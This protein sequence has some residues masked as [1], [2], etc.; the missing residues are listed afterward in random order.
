[1]LAVTVLGALGLGYLMLFSS[2]LGARSVEVTGI[3]LLTA[4]EVRAAADVPAG[5]PLSRLDT[6]AVAGRVSGLLPVAAVEVVRSWPSTVT[7]RV[8]ERVPVA[9]IVVP[10]GARL[11]DRTGV[12]FATI[13]A[14]P[15][16]TPELLSGNADATT[17]AAAV[18]DTLAQPGREPLRAA[19]LSVRADT[20]FDVQLTLTD[21]RTV[22]WGS[23]T[24]SDRKA[25]VLAAL[26]SQPGTVFDVASPDLPTIR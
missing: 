4:D 25:A 20:A 5:T 24:E 13:A 9:Y 26:L 11:V 8:T 6:G 21:G 1:M 2:V 7:V 18:I 3:G 10:D 17:A 16:G 22:R 15:P 12:E 14:A 19:L 23:A